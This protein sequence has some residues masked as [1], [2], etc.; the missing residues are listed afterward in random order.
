MN[1]YEVIEESPDIQIVTPT[2]TMVGRDGYQHIVKLWDK[3]FIYKE[4][5]DDKY[6]PSPYIDKYAYEA[7]MKL[8]SPDQDASKIIKRSNRYKARCAV[9]DAFKELFR[10]LKQWITT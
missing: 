1:K 4:E 9:K 6:V 8:G 2:I 10:T 3:Y 7:L 5:G